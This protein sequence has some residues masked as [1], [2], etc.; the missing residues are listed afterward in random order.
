MDKVVEFANFWKSCSYEEK[1]ALSLC[2]ICCVSE[3]SGLPDMAYK[4]G[5][6]IIINHMRGNQEVI[7][8]AR[9]SLELFDEIQKAESP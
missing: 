6:G 1:V 3:L 8:K 7:T 5:D 9:T 4:L 2:L